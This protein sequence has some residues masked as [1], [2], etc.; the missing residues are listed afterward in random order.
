VPAV[1]AEQARKNTESASRIGLPVPLSGEQMLAIQAKRA[2]DPGTRMTPAPAVRVEKLAGVP[3]GRSARVSP[4]AAIGVA[5]AP[6]K[7]YPTADH[8]NAPTSL[9]SWRSFAARLGPIPRPEWSAPWMPAKPADLTVSR[10]T[11]K[12]GGE[13]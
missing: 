4:S 12:P 6:G 3:P 5:V 11:K 8:S 10:P 2:A 9:R 7:P 1:W 13:R